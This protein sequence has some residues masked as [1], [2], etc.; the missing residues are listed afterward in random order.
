[1]FGRRRREDEPRTEAPATEVEGAEVEG[2]EVEGAEVEGADGHP[3]TEAT[4]GTAASDTASESAP[5]DRAEGPFDV[6]EAAAD[7]DGMQRID[8]GGLLVAPVEGM[9]LR[10]EVDQ[11]SGAVTNIVLVVGQSA[12][13]LQ[14]FAAPRS[15]GIWDEVRGE[16]LEGVQAQGGGGEE[17]DGP[18][19]RELHAQVPVVLPDGTQALQPVR[20]LGV[21]GPR[22]FLRGVLSG[23][24]VLGGAPA[25][26]LEQVFRATVVVRGDEAM[27]P[28][29]PI[30]LRLPAQAAAASEEAA[31]EAALGDDVE[32]QGPRSADDLNPFERG[33]E[34]TEIR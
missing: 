1:M 19:G 33:P 3:A 34:I 18:F 11:Q 32:T 9:E 24:A 20:F 5:F 6:S 14:A 8:M 17:A 4:V 2:A 25:A 15:S 26:Q 28:R 10:A 31:D 7:V 30:P 29:E 12:L 21:D 13:Q 23:E 16:I 22:W 27:P